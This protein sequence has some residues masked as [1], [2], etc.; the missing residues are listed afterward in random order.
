MIEVDVNQAASYAL[1]DVC[2]DVDMA[3]AP[4]LDEMLSAIVDRNGSTSLI[5]DLTSCKYLDSSGLGVLI[6]HRKAGGRIVVILPPHHQLQRLF[7]ITRM[8][9]VFTIVGSRFA[10]TQYLEGPRQEG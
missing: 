1:V 7:S 8:H 3:S 4:E 6:R 9:D 2:R 10:A 5:V